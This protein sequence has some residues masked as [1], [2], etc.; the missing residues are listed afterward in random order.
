MADQKTPSAAFLGVTTAIESVAFL[1]QT[2]HMILAIRVAWFEN[3]VV[4]PSTDSPSQTTQVDRGGTWFDRIIAIIMILLWLYGGFNIALA[5]LSG[6]DGQLAF[7]FCVATVDTVFFS[8][9]SIYLWL[10]VRR[11]GVVYGAVRVGINPKWFKAFEIL[12]ICCMTLSAGPVVLFDWVAVFQRHDIPE[13]QPDGSSTNGVVLTFIYNTFVLLVDC[14]VSLILYVTL[15][16]AVAELRDVMKPGIQPWNDPSSALKPALSKEMVQVEQQPATMSI[17]SPPLRT[18]HHNLSN[19]SMLRSTGV[20]VTWLVSISI[21][22]AILAIV[23]NLL[24]QDQLS[25]AHGVLLHLAWTTPIWHARF[26]WIYLASVKDLVKEMSNR[27]P[28]SYKD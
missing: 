6:R 21:V 16:K 19:V 2:Y 26:A 9:G 1:F 22:G 23:D 18:K 12:T 8:G 14:A 24:I 17:L 11:F 20:G 4:P 25:L 13:W 10:V 3:H 27:H 5:L 15:K 28:Q 7:Q